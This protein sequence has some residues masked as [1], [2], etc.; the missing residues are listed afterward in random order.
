MVPKAYKCLFL[1]SC[2][3]KSRGNAGVC[4][5]HG[6][7]HMDV[8][9]GSLPLSG[10][11]HCDSRMNAEAPAASSI[12]QA[13]NRHKEDGAY[14]REVKLTQISSVDIFLARIISAVML[15]C[16]RSWEMSFF[17]NWRHC[18]PPTK[19]SSVKK[20]EKA[21]WIGD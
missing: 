14:I 8:R 4:Y 16:K 10:P 15:N 17:F 1:F 5:W 18:L 7:R 19:W 12:F 3:K 13:E 6:Q 2:N 20:G 11:F 9:T 21:S